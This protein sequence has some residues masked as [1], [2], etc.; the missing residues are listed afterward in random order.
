MNYLLKEQRYFHKQHPK[1]METALTSNKYVT[2]HEGVQKLHLNIKGEVVDE[3]HNVICPAEIK[4]KM[5]SSSNAASM[6]N[7]KFYSRML[8]GTPFRIYWYKYPNALNG[9]YHVSSNTEVYPYVSTSITEQVNFANLE[10]DLI[11]YATLLPNGKLVLC[12]ITDRKGQAIKNIAHLVRS[13]RESFTYIRLFHKCGEKELAWVLDS[14][15]GDMSEEQPGVVLYGETANEV[16]DVA[17]PK[18]VKLVKQQL[19]KLA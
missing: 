11:Y 9:V 1:M 7:L 6:P 10:P 8:T 5:L 14:L 3:K 13:G 19:Q 15:I 4:P 16:Y 18:H 2:L 12:F 17:N